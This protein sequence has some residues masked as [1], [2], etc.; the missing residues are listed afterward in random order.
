MKLTLLFVSITALAIS[1]LVFYFGYRL[2]CGPAMLFPPHCADLDRFGAFYATNLRGSLFTGFFT[3]GGFMLS[4]K[5]F[6]IVNMKKEVYDDAS[7]VEEW[8]NQKKLD[9]TGVLGTRYSPLRALSAALFSAI[10]ACVTTSALQMT[11][12]LFG[13]YWAAAVCLSSA[14]L[15]L[16]LLA[17]SLV[18]IRGNLNKMFDYLDEKCR[19]SNVA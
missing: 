18:R 1:L 3:L 15:A 7:Y 5:T 6:I 13:T 4:L 10:V 9:K 16:A 12:G 19:K 8:Q 11:L 2:S 14:I 17:V